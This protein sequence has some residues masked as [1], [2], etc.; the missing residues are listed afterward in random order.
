MSEPHGSKAST[1]VTMHEEPP[2]GEGI[3]QWQKH[4]EVPEHLEKYFLLPQY[5]RHSTNKNCRYWTQRYLIWDRYDEGV[6]MTEDSW[7]G[8]TPE[9][10]AKYVEVSVFTPDYR[11]TDSF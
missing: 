4:H 5:C 3:Y 7:F 9:T 11:V 2:E 10:I 1:K 8:V 6:W